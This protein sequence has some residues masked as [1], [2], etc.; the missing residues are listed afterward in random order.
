MLTGQA[1]LGFRSHS[2]WT[3]MVAVGGA[4]AAPAVLLRRRVELVDGAIRGAAQPFH[5][6]AKMALPDAEAFLRNCAET[7]GA[8]ARSALQAVLAELADQGHQTVACGLLLGSGR[9]TGELAAVLASHAAIHTA[10]GVFFRDALKQ[11]AESLGLT[12]A[13]IRE[14]DVW[15]EGAAS[16]GIPVTELH[17]RISALGK[18]LGPPWR[19]DEKFSTVAAWAALA[20]AVRGFRTTSRS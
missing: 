19:Q 12:V 3:A 5:A 7:A 4:A 15:S 1:A 20:S 10:E 13:G 18:S 11:A 16:L 14:R 6:A 2:G 9:P 8:M 17:Q